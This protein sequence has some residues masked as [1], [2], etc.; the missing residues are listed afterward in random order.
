MREFDKETGQFPLDADFETHKLT[1]KQC[2]SVDA[3]P[4]SLALLC[5]EGAVLWKNENTVPIKRGPVDKPENFAT[6]AQ[7]KAAM[8]Y[9]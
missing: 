8:R 9:K 4:S 6:K 7:V 2:G 5:L 3:R 1:C